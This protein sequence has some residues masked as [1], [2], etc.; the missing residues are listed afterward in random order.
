MRKIFTI[1]LLVAT[2]FT[3]QAQ[4]KQIEDC[5][6]PAPEKV[7]YVQI[8]SYTKEKKRAKEESLD[9][10][11]QEKLLKMSCVDLKNDS[12]GNHYTKGKLYVEQV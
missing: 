1:C 7:D 8:C 3:I 10:L 5:N 6:C 2:A 12:P 4:E 11:F 9:Y